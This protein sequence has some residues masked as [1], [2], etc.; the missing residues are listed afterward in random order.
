MKDEYCFNCRKITPHF[1]SQTAGMTGSCAHCGWITVK[2]GSFHC[3]SCSVQNKMAEDVNRCDGCEMPPKKPQEPEH[4][5]VPKKD[6]ATLSAYEQAQMMDMECAVLDDIRNSP[7]KPGVEHLL[8]AVD[9]LNDMISMKLGKEIAEI[10]RPIYAKSLRRHGDK[11]NPVPTPAAGDS[12]Y[13]PVHYTQWEIEP[14]TFLML[15]GVPFAEG[16]A[17]KYLMR[18]KKKNGVEDLKKAARLIEMLIE[19]TENREDYIAKKTCL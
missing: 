7:A 2:K 10:H 8:N 16:A 1:D 17:I 3:E 4:Q 14:F 12:V 6:T 9:T 11:A 13:R 18:W 15:N 19:M 5:E